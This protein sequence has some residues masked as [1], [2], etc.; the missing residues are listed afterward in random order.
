ML[1]GPVNWDPLYIILQICA[2]QSWF[3]F[4]WTFIHSLVYI[5]FNFRQYLVVNVLFSEELFI[6]ILSFLFDDSAQ[7][8]WITT[9]ELIVTCTIMSYIVMLIVER[10]KFCLDFCST[11]FIIHL[12]FTIIIHGLPLSKLWWMVYV[13]S[14]VYF[15]SLSEKLCNQ[16]EMQ[17]ISVT[18]LLNYAV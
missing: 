14:F 5:L 12:M 1:Y 15:T 17:E 3:Y 7:A 16:Q 4:I 9:I 18:T 8:A 2:L 11:I 6:F 10:T 13:L